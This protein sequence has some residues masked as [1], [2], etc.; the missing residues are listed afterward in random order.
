MQ[1][2]ETYVAGVTK[3]TEFE[4][5]NEDQQILTLRTNQQGTSSTML[6]TAKKPQYRIA[7]RNKRKRG[8]HSREEKRKMAGEGDAWTTVT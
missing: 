2:E 7:G 1:L 8:Q 5:I 4:D 6:Q 3:L